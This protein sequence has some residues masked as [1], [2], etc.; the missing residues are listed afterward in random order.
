MGKMQALWIAGEG[1]KPEL[2]GAKFGDLA[3]FS[4][5]AKDKKSAAAAWL[6]R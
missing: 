2:F 3:A 1:A 4:G 6:L 5:D